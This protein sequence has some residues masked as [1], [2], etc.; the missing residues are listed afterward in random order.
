MKGA[1]FLMLLSAESVFEPFSM[2]VLWSLVLLLR[3]S[4][5]PLPFFKKPPNTVDL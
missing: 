1:E 4:G 2:E 5:G 3:E